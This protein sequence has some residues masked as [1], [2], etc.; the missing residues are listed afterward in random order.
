MSQTSNV[1]SSNSM[2]YHYV[3]ATKTGK[4]KKGVSELASRNSVI[5]DL[6]SRGLIPVSVD[7]IKTRDAVTKLISLF[8]G[9]VSHVEKVL[10]T[11]HLSVM[12]RAGLSLLETLNILEDQ[13]STFRVRFICRHLVKRISRGERFSDALAD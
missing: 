2:P 1:K 8:L 5:M 13:A 12:L 11:K 7:E 3:A 6:E 9:T 4:L 10:F